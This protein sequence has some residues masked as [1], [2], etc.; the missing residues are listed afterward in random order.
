[1]CSQEIIVKLFIQSEKCCGFGECVALAPDVFA[2][3]AD[4]R[5][6]LLGDGTVEEGDEARVRGAAFGCPTEAIEV[7]E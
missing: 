2:L 7:R 3:G 6:V 4:N 5:A 1:V